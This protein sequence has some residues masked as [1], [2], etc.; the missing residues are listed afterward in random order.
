[1]DKLTTNILIA[2]LEAISP[3]FKAT[4]PTPAAV[5]VNGS[6]CLM[7]IRSIELDGTGKL[8]MTDGRGRESEVTDNLIY[9]PAILKTIDEAVNVY[10]PFLLVDEVDNFRVLIHDKI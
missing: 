8:F 2:R 6:F 10:M 7:Y 9:S 4:F 3:D 1:M 5:S